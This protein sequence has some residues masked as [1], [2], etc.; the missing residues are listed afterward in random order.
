MKR[1][2]LIGVLVVAACLIAVSGCAL[3]EPQAEVKINSTNSDGGPDNWYMDI[4]YTIDN[5]GLYSI[6]YWE[7]FFRVNC[8][9]DVKEEDS[10][11]G[12]NLAV[13]DSTTET[14]RI[15]TYSFEPL[16]AEIIRTEL[17]RE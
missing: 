4:N 6:A 9:G 8:T 16:T 14:L 5:T 15:N 3:I 13:G 7:V 1:W 12:S 17:E 2:Y 10:D 11:Y